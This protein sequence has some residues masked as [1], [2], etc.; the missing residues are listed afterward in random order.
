MVGL[1]S[2]ALGHLSRAEASLTCAGSSL[3]VDLAK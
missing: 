3:P 1:S 2:H